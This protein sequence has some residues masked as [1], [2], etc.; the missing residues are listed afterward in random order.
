MFDSLHMFILF[1]LSLGVSVGSALVLLFSRVPVNFV[2]I[3][4]KLISLPP[5]IALLAL[6]TNQESM[7]I[8]PWRLDALSWLIALFVLTIGLIL[9][10]YCVRYL[11]GD[12]AYRKYFAFFTFTTV[13]DSFAW[14]SDDLRLM[15]LCW[16]ATLLGLTYLIQLNKQWQVAR[17][18]A[19]QAGRLFAGSWLVLLVAVIGLTQATGHW[20]LSL[21]LTPTSLVQLDSWEKTSINLL[22]ILAIMIPAA[23]WPFQGWLLNSVVAPTPVSAVMHAGIVNAGGILLTRF[24][25]LFNGDAAQIVLLV[26]SSISVLVGTGIMLVQVDYKRQL[27]GSTIAQMGFMLIQCALGAY[28]AAMIHAV[29][30]GLFKSTLFL[31]AGSAI[32]QKNPKLQSPGLPTLNRRISGMLLGVLVGMT[33]WFTSAG[34]GYLLVSAF[35]LG[36]S[37]YIAWTQLVLSGQGLIGRMAGIILFVGVALVYTGIHFVFESLLHTAVPNGVQPSLPVALVFL[38]ILLAGLLF[39]VWLA[40]NPSSKAY[41]ILYL[42]LIRLG[43]PQTKMVENHPIHL[44]GFSRKDCC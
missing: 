36:W 27:V 32:Q 34:N 9:Q 16:G 8:G 10:R 15:I 24:S 18:A 44:K 40:R 33:F 13:A 22:L 21:A 12:Y 25:P 7:I 19:K 4:T 3:H 1:C 26:L 42:W 41:A 43:E 31:Q 23:Q 29:L 28:L 14:L 6:V 38:V 39:S 5:L 11:H 2:R 17:N 30:H 20:E 37:A 35:I